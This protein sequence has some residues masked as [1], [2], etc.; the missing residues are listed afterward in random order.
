MSCDTNFWCADAAQPQGCDEVVPQLP[1]DG[2]ALMDGC[3]DNLLFEPPPSVD[4]SINWDDDDWKSED[5]YD[6]ESFQQDLN[7]LLSGTGVQ[8]QPVSSGASPFFPQCQGEV[9]WKNF[10]FVGLEDLPTRPADVWKPSRSI[11]QWAEYHYGLLPAALRLW[12]DKY[13]PSMQCGWSGMVKGRCDMLPVLSTFATSFRPAERKQAIQWLFRQKGVAS[14]LVD[15][16][17]ELWCGLPCTFGLADF[18]VDDDTT[19]L[20]WVMSAADCFLS[21]CDSAGFSNSMVWNPFPNNIDP[22]DFK[23]GGIHEPAAQKNW[24]KLPGV[25]SWVRT[26][27]RDKVWFQ[28]CKEHTVDHSAKNAACVTPASKW[29]DKG[30]FDFLDSKILEL[31]RTRAVVECKTAP[32]V[33]TRL[34][35]APK[36]GTGEAYRIIMDMRPENMAYRSKHVRMEHLGHF[37]SAFNEDGF[38]FSCDL[39]SAYFSV[40][41]DIRLGRTMGFQWAG[42]FYR[43][44]C[45]P[46]GFKLAPYAFVKIGRQILKKWR[47]VGP[48]TWEERWKDEPALRGGARCMLY[49]DDSLGSHKI[50]AAAVWLRNAMMKE[51]EDLGFSMSAKGDLLPFR[52]IRF[53]GLIA[54]LAGRYPSWHVPADKIEAIMNLLNELD[55]KAGQGVPVE[56]QKVAKCVGKLLSVSRAIPAAQLMSRELNKIIYSKGVPDWMGSVS[57]SEFEQACA[58][59]RWMVKAL[60]PHNQHGAPIWADSKLVQVQLTQ[61]AG[62]WAAGFETVEDGAGGSTVHGGTIEFTEEENGLEHVQKELWGLYLS[63]LSQR[64]ALSGKRVSVQV[65]ATATVHYLTE[66]RGGSS[67]LLSN[68][69]KL[70]WA[71]CI[72]FN[73]CITQVTHITGTKMVAAGVDAKS[74][75]SKFARGHECH[76]DDWRLHPQCFL[77]LQEQVGGTFTIDRMA[78]RSSTQCWRFNSVDDVDPDRSQ[79]PGAFA[80]DW[81]VDEYG[82]S[83]LNYC[84]PP[85]ALLPRIFAHVRECRA[86]AVVIVPQWLSQLWWVEAM[87]MTVRK[88]ELPRFCFQYVKD[89]KMTVVD[90]MPFQAVALVLDGGRRVSQS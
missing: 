29:F 14:A 55:S 18:C 90:R 60:E 9:R 19:E 22:A 4:G 63:L 87:S 24:A 39:K 69:V 80:N 49:I 13:E 30:K 16:L 84:F 38:F 81:R 53:L 59:L 23:A 2:V 17:D 34:S 50:F 6:Y 25:S 78:T 44:T 47:A 88:I 77:W 37:S 8:G 67:S 5:S 20:R 12:I 45:L 48:G 62:P 72:R 7:G 71:L 28:K 11:A 51:L 42:R 26:W 82:S 86:V 33:L 57:V 10:H 40:L 85:F 52:S 46:F 75:P 56:V 73:I 65:D 1:A 15:E 66:W 32:D 64:E 70:I 35:L 58:D 76:R 27:V 68:M 79:C 43:F 36:A 31:V 54:H 74:R 21:L 41:V 89:G 61:D 3:D 83:E